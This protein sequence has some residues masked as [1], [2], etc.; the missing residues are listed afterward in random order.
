MRRS[1]LVKL[2]LL[3]KP[4]QK[5]NRRTKF[6]WLQNTWCLKYIDMFSLQPKTNQ[7]KY[8][9]FTEFYCIRMARRQEWN[10]EKICLLFTDSN[11]LSSTFCNPPPI[12]VQNLPTDVFL[13]LQFGSLLNVHIQQ[14]TW[15]VSTRKYT[16]WSFIQTD[17][18]FVPFV[19]SY[20]WF[21][22][23][24]KIQTYKSRWKFGRCSDWSWKQAFMNLQQLSHR[25]WRW[26]LHPNQPP[27]N[28]WWASFNPQH[29]FH[30]ISNH[31]FF[32]GL[33]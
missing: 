30:W 24:S 18:I 12:W 23:V 17:L 14:E 29:L 27:Q 9:D 31:R 19:K 20:P 15:I 4:R 11:L 1:V 3:Q 10:W 7:Q 6:F 33:S 21:A 28:L 2:P 16:C 5:S 13:N 26:Q 8:L 22:F 32:L 25:H